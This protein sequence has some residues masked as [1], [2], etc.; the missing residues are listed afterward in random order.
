MQFDMA[1]I[2]GG[3]GQAGG[4]CLGAAGVIG[5]DPAAWIFVAHLLKQLMS[6]LI[7]TIQLIDF[8]DLVLASPFATNA[9]LKYHHI[10]ISIE[11]WQLYFGG[12]GPHQ[13]LGFQAADE[14]SAVRPQTADAVDD[15][16]RAG[17][18]GDDQNFSHG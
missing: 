15:G 3:H 4:H 2:N 7:D 1:I 14:D 13:L 11:I 5:N 16:L 17:S 9:L 6:P 10:T 12:D 8:I 18:Q